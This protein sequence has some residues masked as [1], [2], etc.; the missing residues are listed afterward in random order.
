[1]PLRG[2]ICCQN[3]GEGDFDYCLKESL[4]GR[5]AFPPPL[6]SEMAQKEESREGAGISATALLGCPRQYCLQTTEP[7]HESPAD[8]HARW[9]GTG[10]H[11]M[12]ESYGPYPGVIQERRIRLVVETPAGTAELT[13]KPDWYDA[14]RAYLEDWKS[15][16][17]APSAPYDDHIAQVNT[18]AHLIQN[19]AFDDGIRESMPDREEATDFKVNSAAIRYVDPDRSVALPVE[20]WHDSYTARFI[21]SRMTPLV[22]FLA[23]DELPHGIATDAAQG[24]K[25]RYCVFRGTGMCCADSQN[26]E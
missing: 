10:V 7:Y 26:R 9:R 3:G 15:T 2:T 16:K 19:G 13:G 21:R 17:K 1:M 23:T 25:T 11:A 12:A 18:Y 24:W 22:H 20:L 14:N 5:C 8:Y 4:A 6:I